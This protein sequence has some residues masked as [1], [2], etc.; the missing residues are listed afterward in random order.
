MS[1]IS[2]SV[3]LAIDCGGREAVSTDVVIMEEV[4]MELE[5]LVA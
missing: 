3:F 5:V 1:R 2:L 4:E